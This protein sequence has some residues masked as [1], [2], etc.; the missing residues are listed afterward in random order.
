V[1]ITEDQRAAYAEALA[2]AEAAWVGAEL[3]GLGGGCPPQVAAVAAVLSMDAD[4][5]WDHVEGC[6]GW[7]PHDQGYEEAAWAAAECE[8]EHGGECHP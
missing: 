8:R 2:K 3:A 6:H 4:K 7:E 1:T 5:L